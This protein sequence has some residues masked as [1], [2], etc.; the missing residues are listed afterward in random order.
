MLATMP[1]KS[2]IVTEGDPLAWVMAPPPNESEEQRAARLAAEAEAK[3]ISDAIDDEL[4]RQA[5]QEKRG[6]KPVKIL[7]LGAC[8]CPSLRHERG[9]ARGR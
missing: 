2:K 1:A 4:Q 6:P 7:L 9:D 8:C 3:R 5:K